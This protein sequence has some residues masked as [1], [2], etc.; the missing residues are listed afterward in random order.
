MGTINDK[1]VSNMNVEINKYL[2]SIRADFYNWTSKTR[3]VDGWVNEQSLVALF[4]K[5]VSIKEGRKYIKVFTQNS[6]HSFI[7]N[8]DDD[9]KFKRGDILMA[10]SY[11]KPARNFA[12]GN[13][14]DGGYAVQWAGV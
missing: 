7:V 10:A 9:I 2:D 8:I 14:L 6:V 1:G 11:N 12:R 13:I 4:N 3:P 5:Q